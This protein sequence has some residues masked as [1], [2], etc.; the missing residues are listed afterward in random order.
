MFHLHLIQ[1]QSGV[2]DDVDPVLKTKPRRFSRVSQFLGD[3][4]T[5]LVLIPSARASVGERT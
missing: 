5:G 4:Q 3:I 1:F 2:V